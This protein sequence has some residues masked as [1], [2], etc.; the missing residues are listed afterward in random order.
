MH[1]VLCASL[2]KPFY[3]EAQKKQFLF[4]IMKET[5]WLQENKA[6]KYENMI[7]IWAKFQRRE[8]VMLL[9]SEGLWGLH[10]LH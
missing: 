2:L 10:L 6:D 4:T 9:S 5:L 8:R 3:C 7:V 1:T